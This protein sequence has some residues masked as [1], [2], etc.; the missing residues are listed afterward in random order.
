M[1][2]IKLFDFIIHH[3]SEKKHETANDLSQQLKQI[4]N[5]KESQKMNDFI[6]V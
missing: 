6:N 4:F 1:T 5:N 3:I 2:W